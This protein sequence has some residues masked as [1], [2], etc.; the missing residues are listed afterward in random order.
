MKIHPLTVLNLP[1]R[2]TTVKKYLEIVR[3][4][5]GKEQGLN[6]VAK[7]FRIS[8]ATVINA[9]KAFGLTYDEVKHQRALPQIEVVEKQLA[10]ADTI[11]QR[12]RTIVEI[13]NSPS[14]PTLK[15]IGQQVGVTRQRIHQILLEAKR[16]GVHVERR[17]PKQGHW[18]ERC[19]ICCQMRELAVFKS[20]ITTQ[21]IALTLKIPIWKV[22]WHLQKLRAEEF[23][24]SHFGHFRS[25]RIIQAIKMYN[26]DPS[27]SAWKLGR[28]LGYKN[29]PALFRELRRRGFAYLLSPRKATLVKEQ[30]TCTNIRPVVKH[31]NIVLENWNRKT[32]K[33]VRPHSR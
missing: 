31:S 10:L 27:I 18:I 8:P 16:K 11:D 15:E 5:L 2:S 1:E 13:Y 22:Y 12:S 14:S 7:H 9:S 33:Q 25:E 20:L 26:L 23:V 30:K 21:R 17:K 32:S 4:A 29:L 3:Y 28:Q 6:S 19:Q 24:P